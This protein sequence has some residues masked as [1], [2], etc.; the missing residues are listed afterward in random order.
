MTA[1]QI[2][3]YL[4]NK[5]HEQS[6]QLF[7]FLHLN[8]AVD[9]PTHFNVIVN[10]EPIVIALHSVIK[11]TDREHQQNYKTIQKKPNKQTNIAVFN[12]LEI[13]GKSTSISPQL[14]CLLRKI[15]DII[16]NLTK[17]VGEGNGFI[18]M[19]PSFLTGRLLRVK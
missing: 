13:N 3:V 18:C 5:E 11:T 16:N 4:Y 17:N 6:R 1:L 19:P 2:I 15:V 12:R 7:S 9:H 10:K 8:L 14:S